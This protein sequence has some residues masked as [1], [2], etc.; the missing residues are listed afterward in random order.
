METLWQDLKHG[1]RMLGRNPGVAVIGVVTLALGIAVNT[2]VFSVVN[3][4][5]LRPLPVPQP[6]QIT[7]LALKQAGEKYLQSFSYPDYVDLREQSDS[8]SDIFGY[9]VWRCWLVG[10]LRGALRGWI[11]WWRCDMSDLPAARRECIRLSLG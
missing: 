1:I 3:G 5:I 4:F 2:A 6:E 7:V 11:H 9:R 10:Y 8:F